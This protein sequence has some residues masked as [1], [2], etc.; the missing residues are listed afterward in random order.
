MIFCGLLRVSPVEMTTEQFG[1]KNSIRIRQ[2]TMA[3][4]YGEEV[5][6]RASKTALASCTSRSSTAF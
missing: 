3:E 4:S 6:L 5:A 2:G 1:I